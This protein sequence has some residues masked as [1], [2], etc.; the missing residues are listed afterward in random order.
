MGI[1][2][3]SERFAPA[4]VN[5]TFPIG[6][7]ESVVIGGLTPAQMRIALVLMSLAKSGGRGSISRPDLEQLTCVTL[8]NTHRTIMPILDNAVLEIPDDPEHPLH[9]SPV[10]EKLDF[11][12]GVQK[13]RLGFINFELSAHAG[14]ALG[15]GHYAGQVISI[16]AN[17]LRALGTVGS[18]ILRLQLGALFA[19]EKTSKVQRVR[20]TPDDIMPAFGSYGR[21]GLIS[22]TSKDGEV[23][24]TISLSRT[25]AVL[26]EPAVQEINSVSETL[27]LDWHPIAPGE[28]TKPRW[29]AI[30]ITA[31]KFKKRERG[32]KG[33]S[34]IS[35]GRKRA[36]TLAER[37]RKNR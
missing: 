16:P 22:R 24:E 3:I 19:L 4:D 6:F 8:N 25:A 27:Y 12:P 37:V 33:F 29:R 10:F 20:L 34:S 35:K 1:Q 7:A 30:Q 2:A 13:K 17:E 21:N 31:Q 5:L 9:G 28:G 32:S 18:I 14:H 11:Y 26:I 23:R 36:P 15:F